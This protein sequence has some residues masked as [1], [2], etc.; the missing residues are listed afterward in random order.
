M[1]I[2]NKFGLAQLL[3]VCY[4]MLGAHAAQAAT[5]TYTVQ[6]VMNE[7]LPWPLDHIFK[8]SSPVTG[9]FTLDD[10]KVEVPQFPPTGS[11]WYYGSVSEAHFQTQGLS[12]D[13]AN[14]GT[15]VRPHDAIY[16]TAGP[17]TDGGGTISGTPVSGIG[18]PELN[19]YT[20]VG[21]GIRLDGRQVTNTAFPDASVIT[22]PSPLGEVYFDYIDNRGAYT[23]V[24]AF[25]TQITA[26]SPVPEPSSVAMLSLGLAGL[27]FLRRKSRC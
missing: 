4:M 20:V 9:Q 18:I 19:G 26:V 11:S 8:A 13:M 17:S 25:I 1:Q 5:V 3:L 21:W 2:R 10:S 24:N 12:F 15:F 27:M 23:S 7:T 22:A 16:I 6:A 14:G